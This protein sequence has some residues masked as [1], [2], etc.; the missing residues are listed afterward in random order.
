M[1]WSPP[2]GDTENRAAETEIG[3]WPLKLNP[4]ISFVLC[5][6]TE[7]AMH[8]CLLGSIYP[9]KCCP[10]SDYFVMTSLFVF[11]SPRNTESAVQP[12]VGAESHNAL[13]LQAVKTVFYLCCSQVRCHSVVDTALEFLLNLKMD[14]YRNVLANNSQ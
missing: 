10:M 2:T 12:A 7:D 1:A 13:G 5:V 11:L 6:T 4:N 3:T 14:D 9:S 8:C